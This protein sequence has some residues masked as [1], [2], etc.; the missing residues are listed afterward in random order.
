[1]FMPQRSEFGVLKHGDIELDADR[2]IPALE[3]A[4]KKKEKSEAETAAASQ[5]LANRKPKAARW[6]C[7]QTFPDAEFS[8]EKSMRDS[9]IEAAVPREMFIRV[10]RGTHEKEVVWRPLFPCYVMVRCVPSAYAFQALKRFINV[11]DIIGGNGSYHVIRDEDAHVFMKIA[12]DGD[13]P[14]MATDKTIGELDRAFIHM[15]PFAGFECTVVAVKWC[16]MAR[17]KVRIVV[18]GRPFDIES[19]P[20]AFLKKL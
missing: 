16:R 20:V 8:V 6:Y 17:A 9:G 7:V 3:R 10:K 4:A 19:M 12:E 13:V 11:V 2:V 15:G 14:R 18:Q 1:M 5:S